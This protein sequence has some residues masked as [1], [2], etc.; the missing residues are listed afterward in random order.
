M[1]EATFG[2][3]FGQNTAQRSTRETP[4]LRPASASRPTPQSASGRKSKIKTPASSSSRLVPSSHNTQNLEKSDDGNQS[5]FVTPT[6]IGKR[7]RPGPV[8]EVDEGEEDELERNDEEYRPLSARNKANES[9]RRASS[10]RLN[11]LD[12]VGKENQAPNGQRSGKKR[13][14][15]LVENTFTSEIDELTATNADYEV[16]GHE[17]VVQTTPVP[18]KAGQPDDS[19]KPAGNDAPD[20]PATYSVEARY[21]PR[22]SF[23]SVG[24]LNLGSKQTATK[25]DTAKHAKTT[26][27]DTSDKTSK[28][29]R[30]SATSSEAQA[31][32]SKVATD[33]PTVP[34]I[35]RLRGGRLSSSSGEDQS[36]AAVRR[37][38]QQPTPALAPPYQPPIAVM[39]KSQPDVSLEADELS[40][41]A[42]GPIQAGQSGT[43][44]DPM[45]SLS[46]PSD[47][48]SFAATAASQSSP[49]GANELHSAQ[50]RST[51]T[52]LIMGS[53]R[54]LADSPADWRPATESMSLQDS[55]HS[56]SEPG[57][58]AP[59]TKSPKKRKAQSSPSPPAESSPSRDVDMRP[60]S[61]S[62]GPARKRSKKKPSDTV[63]I[64]IFRLSQPLRNIAKDFDE[65]SD[66]EDLPSQSA[67]ASSEP[68][69]HNTP[70]AIDVLAQVTC[71]ILSARAETL[72]TQSQRLRDKKKR[73]A[74]ERQRNA[75]VQFEE[76]V[77][78][79]LFT[80]TE[81]VDMNTALVG[82]LRAAEKE[83]M[84]LREELLGVRKR[85]EEVA[86]E[87]DEV[88]WAHGNRMERERERK[89]LLE[90][91][92][93]VDVAVRRGR[94][95]RRRKV[96][97]GEEDGEMEMAVEAK[98][99]RMAEVIGNSLEGGGLL[100]TVRK[101][102]EVL[103]KAA[104]TLEGQGG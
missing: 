55:R 29:P 22:K 44:T 42:S 51:Q 35:Q 65:S 6:V 23:Q 93:D 102:N 85:R 66:S 92:Q 5:I 72:H 96:A 60:T 90:G 57:I 80:L 49:S 39:T 54:T 86:L 13:L 88:R 31:S 12:A 70:N 83:K 28:N 48:V 46:R 58:P 61:S 24:K 56:P 76:E 64:T 82:R 99:R 89:A 43:L 79:Q 16:S 98:A 26:K 87:M 91:V 59:K 11:D 38:F 71:E 45:V 84:A 33:K 41:A 75:V 17:Q 25:D 15:K 7:K 34:A 3:T 95:A 69:L 21:I 77:E 8:Q 18:M 19:E 100:E 81:A 1:R 10:T 101:F 62:L 73:L 52:S 104:K 53:D 37:R 78:A 97:D 63:P 32:S 27:K 36:P 94:E 20:T 68:R 2:F 74:L 14:L 103:E 67:C 9:P 40:T 50:Q 30:E 47:R 4:Q